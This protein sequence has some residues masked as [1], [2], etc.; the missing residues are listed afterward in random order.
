MACAE[1]GSTEAMETHVLQSADD[2]EALAPPHAPRWCCATTG[3]ARR[4]LTIRTV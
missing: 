3:C 2:G 4:S 1:A